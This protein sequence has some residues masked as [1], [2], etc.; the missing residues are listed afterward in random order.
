MSKG[1]GKAP[2]KKASLNA[3]I[4]KLQDALAKLI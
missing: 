3:Q 2:A 4:K 1:K